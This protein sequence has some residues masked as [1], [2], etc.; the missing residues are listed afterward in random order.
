[1]ETTLSP[2]INTLCG[3]SATLSKFVGVLFVFLFL[4]ILLN[5]LIC[6]KKKQYLFE[7]QSHSTSRLCNVQV[8]NAENVMFVE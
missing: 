8:S 7:L 6:D 3:A 5:L 1:M 2:C 4:C